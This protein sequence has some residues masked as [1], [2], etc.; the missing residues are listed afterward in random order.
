MNPHNFR[1]SRATF[2]ANHLTEAQMKEYFRW[3]QGSKMAAIYVHLSGRDVDEAILKVYGKKNMENKEQ[4]ILTPKD[5]QRCEETNPSENK[6]CSRCSMPLDKETIIEV[7][8]NDLQRKEA[9]SHLL[10]FAF[11]N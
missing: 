5:C 1:H 4:S 2:F 8:E 10:K 11:I 7:V 6:F 3:T 9:D